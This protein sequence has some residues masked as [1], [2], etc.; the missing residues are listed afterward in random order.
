M[1]MLLKMKELELQMASN[2]VANANGTPE[3]ETKKKK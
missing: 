3:S 2:K 1:E